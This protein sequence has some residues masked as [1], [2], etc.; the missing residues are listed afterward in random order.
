LQVT[1]QAF[2]VTLE[3]RSAAARVV[4]P[5]GEKTGGNLC[6]RVPDNFA[7]EAPNSHTNINVIKRQNNTYSEIVFL[8]DP[9]NH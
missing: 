6:V 8:R 3:R 9:P 5:R 7:D 1:D 4:T 2:L